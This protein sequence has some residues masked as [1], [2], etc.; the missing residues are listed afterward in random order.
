LEWSIRS[1]KPSEQVELHALCRDVLD[2]AWSSE[3]I[4]SAF[5]SVGARVWVA[6]AADG[7]LL[8][9]VLARRIVDLLE[10]DLVGVIADSRRRG[11]AA[12]LLRSLIAEEVAAGLAEARLE[13]AESNRAAQALYLG[14]DFMVVGRRSRYYPDG[15]DALLLSS[16]WIPGQGLALKEPPDA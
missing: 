11:V 9:F 5:D 12:S 8:G 14:L 15:E 10:I 2:A 1:G 4:A 13:L 7:R 16:S 6:E 3:S